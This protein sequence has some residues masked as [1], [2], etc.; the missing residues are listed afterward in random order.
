MAAQGESPSG[1][2][3]GDHDAIRT[4]VRTVGAEGGVSA[5]L[6]AGY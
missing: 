5:G 4:R 3:D 2:T 1:I 6:E